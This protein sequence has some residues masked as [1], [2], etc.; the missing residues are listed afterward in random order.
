MI[1]GRLSRP[2]G[3]AAV[4][5]ARMLAE[6]PG[7]VAVLF[8][9]NLLRDPDADGLLDIYVLTESARAYHGAGIAAL[10]NR[11]LPPNVYFEELPDGTAAKVAVMRL[12]AFHR[13]MRWTSWD[14]TLWA[15]FAQPAALLFSRDDAVANKV[16]DAV[17][18][19]HETA[20]RW[21]ASLS[22]PG[23]DADAQ[24]AW[25]TLFEN[26]YGAELRVE[27]RGRAADITA[28]AM[29]TYAAL[30]AAQKI[31]TPAN[32]NK[33]RRAWRGRRF[34]GKFLN[35]ARLIKAAFTFR[36]GIA[37]ALGKVERHSGRPVTLGR[38]ESRFPWLAAPVVFLRLLRERRLR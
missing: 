33:A 37:Y 24:V 29:D 20:A 32:R 8:Y 18:T 21:A 6:R 25:Q 36:G 7:V 14:T 10:A 31:P 5:M 9:G 23:A 11:V 12:S 38:W 3:E 1:A 19:A 13:R 28:T 16:R 26:T 15:R 35:A 22:G 30:H 34:V 2:A 27:G 4:A 17:V